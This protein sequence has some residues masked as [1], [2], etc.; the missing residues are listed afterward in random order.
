M[1]PVIAVAIAVVGAYAGYKWLQGGF[2][3]H[4]SSDP[5]PADAE[6]STSAPGEG[7]VDRGDLQFDETKGVYRLSKRTDR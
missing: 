7:P 2:G 1:P 5:G 3:S 4:N 6:G